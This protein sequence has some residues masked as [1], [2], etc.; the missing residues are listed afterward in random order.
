MRVLFLLSLISSALSDGC[1]AFGGNGAATLLGVGTITLPGHTQTSTQLPVAVVSSGITAAPFISIVFAPK[2]SPEDSLLGWFIS[3]NVTAQTLYV[4]SNTTGT[5]TCSTASV[6]LP[7]FYVP[8]FSQCSGAA[9]GALWSKFSGDYNLG[10]NAP[11]EQWSTIR[12]DSTAAFLPSQGCTPVY[13]SS[14]NN[15]FGTG[16]FSISFQS[17]DSGAPSWKPPTYCK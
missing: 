6:A 8:G 3:Q 15:P 4:W 2:T 16:A 11:V 14:A 7:E 12:G 9:H 17:G 10:K 13:M 1:C 5:P